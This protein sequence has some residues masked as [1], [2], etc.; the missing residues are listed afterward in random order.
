MCKKVFIMLMAIGVSLVAMA[1]QVGIFTDCN[2]AGRNSYLSVGRYQ[3][4]QMNIPNDRLSSLQVPFGMKITVYE[5]DD[6]QGRSK[7]YFGNTPCLETEWRNAASSLIVEWDDRVQNQQGGQNDYVVVYADCYQ[8]GLSQTL[9]PGT[10]TGNQLGSLKYNISSFTISGNLR[11]KLYLNNEY[12][13]G[14]ATAYEASTSCLFQGE[15]D[16][17]G[18]V[19]VE[20]KPTTQGGGNPG[21]GN[22]GTGD[23]FATFYT[24][25]DF[26]GNAL[27]L[28]P[29]NYTGAKLGLLKNS[30]ASVQVPQGL[31]V[32]AYSSENMFGSSNLLTDDMNCLD[33]N[34]R[35]RIASL[36]VEYRNGSGVGNA[37]QGGN[38]NVII[39]AD[40]N[41]RGQSATLL[42]GN[43]ATMAA[44]GNFSDD[45]V[46]S[47]YVPQGYRV[48]LYELEN[49]GGKNF[50]LIAS[51]SS[52][53][54]TKWNDRTSSIA[55]YKDR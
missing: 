52:F 19:V 39:Y 50:T 23:E 30:I 41:Y 25:C 44:A 45:A 10:Y 15:N 40:D 53:F 18:S 47:V 55:V 29:G 49:F 33:N 43:Y 1:Q 34:L 20:Y 38:D 4:Y 24:E 36:V 3:S 22:S 54:L 2:Y 27:R 28:M 14:N 5:H 7:T 17:T 8:R 32:K 35:N 48:V 46:S 37:Q 11:I 26:R 16:K 6:F 31:R 42:P 13:S 9:R 21:G 51:R 12:A